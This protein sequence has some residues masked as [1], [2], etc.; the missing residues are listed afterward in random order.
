MKI[1]KIENKEINLKNALVDKDGVSLN[2]KLKKNEITSSE[3]LSELVKRKGYENIKEYT[4]ELAKKRGYKNHSEY[5]KMR[6][7][8]NNHCLP[9]NKNKECSSYMGD[10]AE[11]ILPHIFEDEVTR[12]P[13]GNIGYDFL[14]GKGYKNDVK[15]PV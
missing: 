14:C 7:Y 9:M 3:Y 15:V 10:I 6:R 12:M 11:R 5:V 8:E 1:C 13:Y 4:D 2:S